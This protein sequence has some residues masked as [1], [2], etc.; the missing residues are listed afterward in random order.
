MWL[1]VIFANTSLFPAGVNPDTV[2]GMREIEA[3][4]QTV[5]SAAFLAEIT[6]VLT[7][8]PQ[9]L[10]TADGDTLYKEYSLLIDGLDNL[11]PQFAQAADQRLISL[12]QVVLEAYQHAQPLEEALEERHY[13]FDTADLPFVTQYSASWLCN[14]L[15][16][17]IHGEEEPYNAVSPGIAVVQPPPELSYAAA[18]ATEAEPTFET[19][20]A[21]ETQEL[22]PPLSNDETLSAAPEEMTEEE[23][24]ERAAQDDKPDGTTDTDTVHFYLRRIGK[25]P[26][27]TA[28]EEVELATQI[29]AG[30]FAGEKLAAQGDELR[31]QQPGL[32]RDL[33]LIVRQGERAKNHLIEANL[34]LA[35]SIAKRYRGRGMAFLDLIQSANMG[36]I[37]A[38][39][40]FD[41]TKGFKFSTYATWWI[42]QSVRRSLADE[43]RTI[44]LPVHVVDMLSKLRRI[45]ADLLRD[46]GRT[47]TNKEIAKEAGITTEK[48][49]ELLQDAR[50]SVSL[51][52]LVGDQSDAALEEFV[53]D[54]AIPDT[55]DSLSERAVYDA[56][57]GIFARALTQ[58]EQF[59]LKSRFNNDDSFVEIGRALGMTTQAAGIVAARAL[60][61]LAH[62][63][64]QLGETI[65]GIIGGEAWYALSL[66]HI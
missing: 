30:I 59:V 10:A 62:P 1:V 23:F 60:A 53:A 4:F 43:S 54:D 56:F 14:H 39:E 55:A 57:Q 58:Q 64:F 27:L 46:L 44:R 29:E 50:Q 36:L 18:F 40:K 45:Q 21:A 41:C 51:N 42:R 17:G 32:Y 5:P 24:W 2:K 37:R 65:D 13:I 61:K 38:V 9:E 47:P 49:E 35:V 31:R 26:L 11:R 48:L 22:E 12:I 33:R 63:A 19:M 20:A 28:E 7:V 25:V 15:I 66:I 8:S 34:R 52:L 3:Q 6:P 16:T